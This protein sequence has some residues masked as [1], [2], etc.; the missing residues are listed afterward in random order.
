MR[1]DLGDKIKFL[2]EGPESA[3]CA[4]RDCPLIVRLDG[5]TFSR[6]TR[7]L[8][9]PIDDSFASAM[10]ETTSHLIEAFKAHIGYTQSDEITLMLVNENPSSE[11][12]FGG[13]YQKICSVFAGLATAKFI[14]VTTQN[15]AARLPHFDARA[16]SVPSV[17]DGYSVF[18]WREADA[19]RNAVLSLGQT[20]IGKKKIMGIGT[21]DVA[22]RLRVEFHQ[23]VENYGQHFARGT[24]LRRVT[25]RIELTEDQRAKIPEK[26]RPDTGALFLRS[27]VEECPAPTPPHGKDE[28]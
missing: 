2:W 22:D 12:P 23:C 13:K 28:R 3:R 7:D 15:V 17:E 10:Q 6:V 20:V 1:D 16:F 27:M 14:S 5:R 4:P 25:K 11:F 9:K 19:R 26:Y 18:R 8:K 21:R 24:Y